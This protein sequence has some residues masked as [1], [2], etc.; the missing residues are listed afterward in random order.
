M[1]EEVSTKELETV[2]LGMDLGVQRGGRGSGSSPICDRPLC[3]HFCDDA[4]RI[5]LCSHTHQLEVVVHKRVGDCILQTVGLQVIQRAMT[6]GRRTV[7][8]SAL[9]GGG[10]NGY[11]FPCAKGSRR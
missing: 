3:P 9:K 8:S 11:G 2:L 5:H 10:G 6:R 4:T 1:D 7:C